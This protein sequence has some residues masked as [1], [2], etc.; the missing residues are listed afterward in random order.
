MNNDNDGFCGFHGNENS[1]EIA[2]RSEH[3]GFR[4]A[5]EGLH[6]AEGGEVGCLAERPRRVVRGSQAVK[7][8]EAVVEE[9]CE[10]KRKGPEAKKGVQP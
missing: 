3:F 7:T 6:C 9:K 1:G 2:R 10:R 4:D 8:G 5:T